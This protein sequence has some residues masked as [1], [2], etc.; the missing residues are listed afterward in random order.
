MK[1]RRDEPVL[2]TSAAEARPEE[3]RRREQRYVLMMLFRVV[4]FVLAVVAFTGWL[5]I[6]AVGVAVILPWIAVVFA[7]GGPPRSDRRQAG[8]AARDPGQSDLPELSAGHTVVDAS[9]VDSGADSVR[10][11]ST[12]AGHDPAFGGMAAHGAVAEDPATDV[13]PAGPAGDD[14]A[15]PASGP[16]VIDAVVVAS[17]LVDPPA[18]GFVQT[19]GPGR[20]G[21]PGDQ[22]RAAGA[23]RLRPRL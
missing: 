19:G 21:C 7:N 2:I 10:A 6:V 12:P 13:Q 17:T 11:D 5:R 3:I 8:Y 18:D 4:C 1:W 14:P 22:N 16:T 9:V 15:G 20:A 23:R